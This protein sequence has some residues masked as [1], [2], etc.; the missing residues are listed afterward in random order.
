MELII[1]SS[2]HWLG[3][4]VCFVMSYII[5]IVLTVACGCVGGGIM[6]AVEAKKVKY[7]F[8]V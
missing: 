7:E 5:N 3:Q 4:Q 6:K 8:F 2:F 1:F